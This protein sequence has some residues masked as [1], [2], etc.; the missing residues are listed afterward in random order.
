M[1]PDSGVIGYSLPW[2]VMKDSLMAFWSKTGIRGGNRQ[3][4]R[5][6]FRLNAL[7]TPS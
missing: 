6:L 2:R 4:R 1:R 5:T 3:F 7:K